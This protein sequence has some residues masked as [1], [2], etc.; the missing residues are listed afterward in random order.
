LTPEQLWDLTFKELDL[1][2]GHQQDKKNLSYDTTRILGSWILS[3]Y[4]KRRVKP[5]DL[6]KLPSEKPIKPSTQEQFEEALRKYG[7]NSGTNS[8]I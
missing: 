6:L 3:P 8:R 4:S 2:V 5:A 1:L 7:T